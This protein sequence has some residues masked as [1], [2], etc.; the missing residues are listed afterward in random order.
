[1]DSVT[2]VVS[3]LLGGQQREGEC[4][5]TD[6]GQRRDRPALES[7][8]QPAQS[9]NPDALPSASPPPGLA[10]MMQLAQELKTLA[11]DLGV[12]VVVRKWA[13]PVVLVV[14]LIPGLHQA[15]RS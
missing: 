5:D 14:P 7:S 13:W 6:Q 15:G 11:Q 10:L 8:L 3:P 12:A 2:A 1:M 9:L 4:C